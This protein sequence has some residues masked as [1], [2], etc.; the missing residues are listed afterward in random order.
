MTKKTKNALT[1]V[2][3]LAIIMGMIAFAASTVCGITGKYDEKPSGTV[4][5]VADPSFTLKGKT[6]SFLGDSITTYKGWSNNTGHN[7]TLGKNATF[8]DS[9]WMGVNDTWWKQVLNE[10]QL[11]L[12]VNNSCDAGRVTE[13]NDLPD[14]V[15]RA[16]ELARDNGTSPDVIVVYLGTNDLAADEED[17]PFDKDTVYD[18]IGFIQSYDDMIDEI[19]RT[20]P[21]ANIFVCTLLPEGRNNEEELLEYNEAIREIANDKGV[22]VIDLYADSGITRANY[23]QYVIDQG[24]LCVHPNEAGMD[25]ITDTVVK[26]LTEFY[27]R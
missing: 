6:I 11:S 17:V 23:L 9:T 5:D 1:V 7:A 16:S 21:Y 15:V 8:Y 12:C 22:T 19:R 3:V 24:T 14:G 25:L 26:A 27:R 4:T 18:G 13:T 2:L 10:L 20:C